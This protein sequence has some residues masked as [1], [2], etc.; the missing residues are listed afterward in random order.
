MKSASISSSGNTPPGVA[1]A[2]K[3]VSSGR[4]SS[5]SNSP[6]RM[7][8]GMSPTVENSVL[9][10]ACASIH[11][12]Y[13]NAMSRNVQPFIDGKCASTIHSAAIADP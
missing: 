8:S 5:R 12:P 11:S 10:S 6:S 4:T 3:S 7:W 9:C 1:I 13:R 2:W